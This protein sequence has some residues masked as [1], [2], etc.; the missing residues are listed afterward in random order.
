MKH[1]DGHGAFILCAPCK[2]T[3]YDHS[4]QDLLTPVWLRPHIYV[5]SLYTGDMCGQSAG[6]KLPRRLNRVRWC[7]IFV[8]DLVDG[9]LR[10]RLRGYN[11]VAPRPIS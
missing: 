6:A 8:G 11:P 4:Q 7:L 2:K 5:H 9:R 10:S 3:A 1:A